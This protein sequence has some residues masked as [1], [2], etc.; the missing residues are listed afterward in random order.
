MCV[1]FSEVNMVQTGK[2][3]ELLKYMH[4]LMYFIRFRALIDVW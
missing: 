3:T 2:V 1:I 4:V